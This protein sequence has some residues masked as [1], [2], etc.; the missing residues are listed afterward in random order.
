MKTQLRKEFYE[1]LDSEISREDKIE[2]LRGLYDEADARGQNELKQEI[3]DEI[4][5]MI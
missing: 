2:E 1:I 5:Y 4:D 3:E